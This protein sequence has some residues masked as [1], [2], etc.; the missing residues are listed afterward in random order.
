MKPHQRINPAQVKLLNV[1]LGRLGLDREDFKA[2]FGVKS[3]KALTLSQ[4]EAAMQYLADCGFEYKPKKEPSARVAA[5]ARIKQ[6]YIAA[7]EGLL[8][9]LDRPWA[10]A[11]G[12]SRRMFRVGRLEWLKPWQLHKVQIALI[13]EANPEA[14]ERRKGRRAGTPAPLQTGTPAPLGTPVI[15][16]GI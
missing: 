16:E 7:I 3:T 2:R 11:E 14:K 4:F 9:N 15:Q 1:A 5:V 8:A 12:I 13:Y 10:Y 6:A